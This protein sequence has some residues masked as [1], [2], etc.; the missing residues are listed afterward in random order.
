MQVMPSPEARVLPGLGKARHLTVTYSI[1]KLGSQ[2]SSVT[3]HS[4]GS[5]PTM[6]ISQ[7][8]EAWLPFA[9]HELPNFLK[10]NPCSWKSLPTFQAELS[11]QPRTAVMEMREGAGRPSP[12]LVPATLLHCLTL[13]MATEISHSHCPHTW[14]ALEFLPCGALLGAG[15]GR[16]HKSSHQAT[17]CRYDRQHVG[18]LVRNAGLASRPN[19]VFF[20]SVSVGVLGSCSNIALYFKKLISSLF[21][22]QQYW[23]NRFL[24]H[25]QKCK[26]V[27]VRAC[28]LLATHLPAL[29]MTDVGE[30]K[31]RNS[32]QLTVWCGG[33]VYYQWGF[34]CL[35]KIITCTI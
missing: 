34:S 12:H 16:K 17:A 11:L 6:P 18:H 28:A 21:P 2:P 15:G 4:T 8:A 7:E 31:T 3:D 26:G 29:C 33:N 13:C 27:R 10:S 25:L 1:L 30:K 19:A 9:M 23:S 20:L 22:F 35:I 14:H 32:S 5:V 24:N